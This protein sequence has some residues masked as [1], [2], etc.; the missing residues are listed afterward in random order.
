MLKT[1]DGVFLK[2]FLTLP[3]EKWTWPK[4]DLW[5]M[6]TIFS[7]IQDEFMDYD[8]GNALGEGKLHSH[9]WKTN[10]TLQKSFTKAMK[11]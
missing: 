11:F 9:Q 7:L 8:F 4:Y 2:R 5:T 10:Y 6:L 1:V 3:E